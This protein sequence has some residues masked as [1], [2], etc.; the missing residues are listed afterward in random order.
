VTTTVVV[1][2]IQAEV[3]E[4]D[5]LVVDVAVEVELTVAVDEVVDTEVDVDVVVLVWAAAA[6]AK[7]G[8]MAAE[9]R[10]LALQTGNNTGCC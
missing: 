8:R 9:A 2:F 6:A 4:L 3:E 1:A 5:Q 10:M 7:T